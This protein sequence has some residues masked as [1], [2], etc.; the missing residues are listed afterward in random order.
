MIITIEGKDYSL[1]VNFSEITLSQRI[2][3][4]RQY[5]KELR[6][7]LTKLIET[8]DEVEFAEY[9]ADVACKTLSFF[10]KIPLETVQA[11]AIEDVL[12]IY[13]EVLEELAVEINFSGE[14]ALYSEFVWNKE[15][16]V[17]A[18]PELK[19]DTKMSFGEFIDA[20]Q[21]VQ[22]MQDTGEERWGALLP[23]CCIYLRKKG[24]KYDKDFV[25]EGGQRMELMKTLPLSIAI[26]VGFFFHLSTN[27]WLSTSRFFGQARQNRVVNL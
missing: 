14:M 22:N 13:T 12:A 3:Y 21:S 19:Q 11:T 16:W 6:D 17:I 24:E 7:R 25:I 23:L 1:P 26:Q 4:D 27:M 9:Q 5:G 8:P 18:P 2:E 20:K 10:G 15:D